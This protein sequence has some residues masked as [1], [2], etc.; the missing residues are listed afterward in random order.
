MNG[1]ILSLETAEKLARIDI[2]LDYI[3]D[4]LRKAYK[5]YNLSGDA[6]A[7]LQ[8]IEALLKGNLENIKEKI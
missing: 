7:I 4:R 6:V 8:G 5:T 2:V 3:D 1:E